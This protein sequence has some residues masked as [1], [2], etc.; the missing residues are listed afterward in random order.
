MTLTDALLARLGRITPG[1]YEI[2]MGADDLA[3]IL[4]ITY[5]GDNTDDPYATHK[6]DLRIG[7]KC[8][9][10][11]NNNADTLLIQDSPTCMQCL[12]Q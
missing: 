3:H 5:V 6:Y 12:R 9:G 7:V 10:P 8:G 4:V 1:D 2:V 11:I